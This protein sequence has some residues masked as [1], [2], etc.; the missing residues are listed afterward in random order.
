[1]VVC[2]GPDG[3]FLIDDQFAPLTDKIKA[4]VAKLTD[5]PVRFVLNTHWHG[6]HTGG[7][8]NFG[9]AGVT[10]IA[11]ENVR[12]RMSTE[13]YIVSLDRRVP[14][15]P[16]KALPIETFAD[17]VTFYLNGEEIHAFHVAPAHTDGDVI[18]WFPKRNVV[19][20]GDCLFNGG[21]PRIDVST[22]GN[23]EGMIAANDRLLAMTDANT[24]YIPGH[25]KLATRADVQAFRDMLVK[26]RDRV[27][28][29]VAAGKGLPDVQAAKP[30]ADLDAQWGTTMMKPE[31]FVEMVYSSLAKK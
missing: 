25:G 18:V 14:P 13:Q 12:K 17:S 19:H 24:K 2:V 30:T 1:M 15:S 28:P 21:Y 8:E 22:G 29:M 31:S 9:N 11:Q 16:E 10:I 4:A 27:K 26:V 7:N 3:A 5:K 23:I 20:M 6:D